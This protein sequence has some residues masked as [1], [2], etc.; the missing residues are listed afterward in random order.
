MSVYL[1]NCLVPQDH[2][3]RLVAQKRNQNQSYYRIDYAQSGVQYPSSISM[4]QSR[5]A[6]AVASF[7]GVP[8]MFRLGMRHIAE[9]TDHLLFLIAL[10]LPAPLL[11]IRHR[12]AAFGLRRLRKLTLPSLN[13]VDHAQNRIQK[14]LRQLV[15]IRAAGTC[16]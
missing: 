16:C 7:A 10:L 1:M 9:G 2:D 12:W 15:I 14:A 4:W 3:I 6:L 5:L 11:S 8:S 13:R